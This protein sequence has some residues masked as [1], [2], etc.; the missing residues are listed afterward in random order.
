MQSNLARWPN[1]VAGP[2]HPDRA[3]PGRAGGRRVS[4]AVVLARVSEEA[5]RWLTRGTRY[6]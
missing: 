4:S 5:V 6:V 1:S 2:A 3:M